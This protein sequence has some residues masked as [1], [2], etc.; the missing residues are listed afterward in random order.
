M[1]KDAVAVNAAFLIG[2]AS[3]YGDGSDS[4]RGYSNQK[5]VFVFEMI[6]H[7]A[8][9]HYEKNV[10]TFDYFGVGQGELT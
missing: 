5:T 3:A 6:R 1:K 7:G 4:G 10:D 9:A 2:E 8:R